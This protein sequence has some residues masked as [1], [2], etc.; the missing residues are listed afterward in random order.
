MTLDLN[1]LLQLGSTLGAVIWCIASIKSS[2]RALGQDL[3]HLST[4]IDKLTQTSESNSAT[5]ATHETRITVLEKARR[6]RR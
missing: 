1:I 4:A 5:V 3:M 2:T 6:T